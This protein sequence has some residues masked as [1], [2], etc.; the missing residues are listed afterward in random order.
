MCMSTCIST[1]KQAQVVDYLYTLWTCDV[2]CSTVQHRS[3]ADLTSISINAH[4]VCMYTQCICMR[5]VHAFIKIKCTVG[6]AI[7][8]YQDQKGE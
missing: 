5:I 6:H 1:G 8:N 4:W 7:I 3:Q 2:H